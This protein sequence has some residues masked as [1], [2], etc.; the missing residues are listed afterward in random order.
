MK[1]KNL[2]KGMAL[3][4]AIGLGM[5]MVVVAASPS[6]IEDVSITVSYED[7]NVDTDAGV[8]SL[9]RRLQ[10]AAVAVCNSRQDST[11]GSR[12][13]ATDSRRCYAEALTSAVENI[14]NDA[15]DEIHAG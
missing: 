13:H 8:K 4:V 7:L 1:R 3:L 10:R 11:V 14:G 5:P 6:Q 15:L 2:Q 12:L 9:Y